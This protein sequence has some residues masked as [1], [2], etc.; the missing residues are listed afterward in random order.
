MKKVIRATEL[1]SYTVTVNFAGYIGADE[2]YDV[3]EA[4]E[5]DA[6]DAAL[7]QAR[8]DLSV[9]DIEEI[10]EGEYE[11]HVGFC[12]YIGVEEVYTVTADSE[13]EAADEALDHAYD[14]L[15]A[16]ISYSEED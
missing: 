1:R 13:D 12:G 16:E 9:E 7:E 8:D 6:I 15:S 14:D 11:V 3:T 10:D 2:D 5:D 4:N